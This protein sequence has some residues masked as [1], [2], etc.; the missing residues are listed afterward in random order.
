MRCL[1]QPRCTGFRVSILMDVGPYDDGTFQYEHNIWLCK[2]NR[3][4][5]KADMRHYVGL[6]AVSLFHPKF[7]G[8]P[9]GV[10]P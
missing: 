2:Q 6:S 10:D 3:L 5:L 8:V 1:V 9:F 7:H 4:C